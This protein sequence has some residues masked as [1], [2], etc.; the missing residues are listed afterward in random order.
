MSDF[1]EVL[2]SEARRYALNMIALWAAGQLGKTGEDAREFAREFLAE[3]ASRD[4]RGRLLDNLSR[5]LVGQGVCTEEE[6]FQKINEYGSVAQA[7]F[8]GGGFQPDCP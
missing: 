3:N 7:Y 8:R 4:R 1:A 6:I 2:D 5:R